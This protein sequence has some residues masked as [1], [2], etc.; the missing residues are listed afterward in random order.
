MKENKK[1]V[2][3]FSI[4]A[5][6]SAGMALP[7]PFKSK[8]KN[9]TIL[10]KDISDRKLDS[11]MKTYTV[12]LGEQCNF[13]HVAQKDSPDSLDYASDADPMKGNARK[14]MLMVIDINKTYFYFNTTVKPVYLNTVTCKTCHRGE[15]IPKE[16]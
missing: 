12:A 2:I 4:V 15:P 14:M 13:C 6:V 3:I 1:I 7:S 11:M 5:F 10:P 16:N 8:G 9:L